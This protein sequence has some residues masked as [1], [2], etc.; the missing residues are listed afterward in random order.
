M[1]Y[2]A[3]C[4]LS[5]GM[6]IISSR[7]NDKLNGQIANTVFQI[8][9][10]PATIAVSINKQNLTHEYIMDSRVFTASILS[11]EAPMQFMGLFGFR[12]GRSIDKFKEIKYKTGKTNAPVV[13]DYSV[14]YLES[15]VINSIDVGT[16]TIIVG[17]VIDGEKISDG[18]P[19]TYEC[20]HDIKKGKSPEAAPTYIKENIQS[21]QGGLK[22]AKYKCTVCGYIY[23]PETGD[24]DSGIKPG[25]PFEK[26]PDTWVCP[27]CG[28]GKDK[29]EKEA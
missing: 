5:Y 6:Y 28:V 2:E 7:K 11:E 16:H 26:I 23:D 1:I 27:I 15:E 21:K 4:K 12:S 18:K 10:D 22:M 3:I 17:K 20:Y 14:A 13:L 24:P 19:M 29:F 9:S 8:T 25:T